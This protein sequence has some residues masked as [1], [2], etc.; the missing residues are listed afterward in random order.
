MTA[1]SRSICSSLQQTLQQKQIKHLKIEEIKTF[2]G[3]ICL[4]YFIIKSPTES[5]TAG[6]HKHCYPLPQNTT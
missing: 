5:A 6:I 4:C 1:T 3:N 2:N